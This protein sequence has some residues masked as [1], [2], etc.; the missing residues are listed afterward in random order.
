[1]NSEGAV[2]QALGS[3]EVLQEEGWTM[4]TH[5]SAKAAKAAAV[6]R[7]GYTF[8]FDA[9]DGFIGRVKFCEWRNRVIC[10]TVTPDGTV[11]V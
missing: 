1:M 8:T 4:F 7:K 10:T 6:A 11:I 5:S 3:G 9:G 2:A